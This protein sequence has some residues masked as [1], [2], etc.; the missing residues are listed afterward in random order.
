MSK[1]YIN[2]NDVVIKNEIP[3]YPRYRQEIKKSFKLSEAVNNKLR[4][5]IRK[6]NPKPLNETIRK[7]RGF[8]YCEPQCGRVSNFFRG[9]GK[10]LG[11][12]FGKFLRF[13]K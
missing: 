11:K 12:G 1:N 8:E 2:P 9:L 5:E 6:C 7:H 10:G 13:I 4:E 3:R